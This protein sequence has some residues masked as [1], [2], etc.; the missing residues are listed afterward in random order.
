MYR[1]ASSVYMYCIWFVSSFSYR[2]ACVNTQFAANLK[3]MLLST[4]LDTVTDCIKVMS[5]IRCLEKEGGMDCLMMVARELVTHQI[6]GIN[7]EAES[8]LLEMLPLCDPSTKHLQE[9]IESIEPCKNRFDTIP[10]HAHVH[11][12]HCLLHLP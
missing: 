5:L 8:L 11:D 7:K 3:S 6:K 9:M 12:T 4:S 10:T 2:K 1:V